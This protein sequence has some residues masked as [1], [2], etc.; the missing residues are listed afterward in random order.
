MFLG[1]KSSRGFTGHPLVLL[2]LITGVV[3]GSASR[4]SAQTF[5]NLY[6]FTTT[7]LSY[8]YRNSD[9]AVPHAGLISSGDRLYG[10]AENGGS[11][12][13][14]TI[15]ALKTDGN[16]FRNLHS[17]SLSGLEGES[18]LA[19]LVLSGNTLF[20]TAWQAGSGGNGTVFAVNSDGTGFRI[21]HSFG[22]YP[23]DGANPTIEL[24][25]SGTALYGKTDYGGAASAHGGT[26]F[27]VNSD[28]GGY[29]I[30]YSF[31]G[32]DDGDTPRHLTLSGS[33]LYG[34][35]AGGGAGGNGTVFALNTDGTGFTTLYSFTA[36]SANG[37]GI[38]TNSDGAGPNGLTL[39]GS[40]LYGTCFSGGGS[41]GGTVFA[42]KVDGTAFTTLHAFSANFNPSTGWPQT[43]SDGT[44]PLGGGVILSGGTLFGTTGYGGASANGVVF[45]LNTSG[46]GFTA[47]HDFS[48]S[49]GALAQGSL[50][51]VSNILYGTTALGGTG[52]NG[53]VFS[54]T[55]QVPRL[56]I[57]RAGMNAVLTWPTNVAGFD[58]SGY[59]LQSTSNLGPAAVWFTNSVA[60]VVVGGQNVV[61]NPITGTQQ[62]YRL[63]Q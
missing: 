22:G 29:G 14:G 26:V 6:N 62:F 30:L 24:V 50:L 10:T 56:S 43:N 8:P 34:T 42:V 39:S 11:W 9:G 40:T 63:S 45:A 55:L 60:P 23:A 13:L 5:G 2:A 15:F 58:Y 37:E 7:S 19:G 33:T 31:T 41:G 17:F 3:S 44:W 47:L 38:S 59:T 53:T 18:P 57:A 4:L 27:S 54:V 51:R 25:V 12:D 28:G 32:G 36:S 35:T 16:G 48:G 1:N 52:N 61:T 21:L 46:S 20:G 49:D